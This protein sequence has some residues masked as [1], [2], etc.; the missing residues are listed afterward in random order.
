MSNEINWIFD[1]F[2]V[3]YEYSQNKMSSNVDEIFK[4]KKKQTIWCLY[5]DHLYTGGRRA[6]K[7]HVINKNIPFF[8]TNRGGEVTY[9]GPGQLVVYS[10]INLNLYKKDISMYVR[11]LEY[12]IY[13]ILK[14]FDIESKSYPERVGL[15]VDSRHGG[16]KKIA[17]I[18]VHVKRWVT[19]HGFSINIC[20]DLSYFDGIIPCGISSYGVTSVENE[21]KTNV[22]ICLESIVKESFYK[23]FEKFYRL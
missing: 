11:F 22:N 7:L 19:S 10:M 21:L 9:H 13:K 20:P 5:H 12:W 1:D 18:G 23:A 16:E 15:W 3:E 2:L 17:S 4:N 6:N 8:D 14:N